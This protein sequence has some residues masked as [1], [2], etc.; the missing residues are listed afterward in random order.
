MLADNIMGGKIIN[1]F[2]RGAS[3]KEDGF[4]F[5]NID[6]SIRYAAICVKMEL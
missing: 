4:S 2:R 5:F 1:S 6:L 3:V